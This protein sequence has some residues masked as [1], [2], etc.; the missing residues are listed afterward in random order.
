MGVSSRSLVRRLRSWSVG[1]PVARGTTIHTCVSSSEN[2]FILAFVRMGGESRPW[3]VAWKPGNSKMK[4][5]AI[6]EPRAREF[7]DEMLE[8]LAEDLAFHLGH[9]Y[10][11][12]VEEPAKRAE[13]DSDD[14]PQIWVP[15]SSHI[16]ML[17]FLS[18]S[19]SRRKGD[20]ELDV[21]LRMLGRT[22]LHLFLETRRPGQQLVIDASAALRSAYDFPCEDVR[23]AH[24]GLLIAWLEN[25]G[26]RDNGIS[27]ALE[28]EQLSVSTALDPSLE[29]EEL[30]DLV[31]AFNKSRRDRG[32]GDRTIEK[33]VETI[34]SAELRRRLD[35]VER[36]IVVLKDDERGPNEGLQELAHST[37]QQLFDG[38]LSREAKALDEDREPFALSPETDWDARSASERYYRNEAS[39]DR[40]RNALIH[41]DRELE[42]EA[43]NEGSAFRGTISNVRDEGR[44]KATAPIWTLTDPVPGVL[45]LRQGDKICVVG[46]PLRTGSIRSIT[47]GPDGSLSM[48][49]EITGRKTAQGDK[50]WPHRMAG[51]D[52]SW[53][54]LSVTVISDSFASM[55]EKKA[56]LAGNREPAPADFLFNRLA[57][58]PRVDGDDES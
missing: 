11:D 25:R 20:Q 48:E 23:Q 4:F 40:E 22:A 13:F 39:R 55:T 32:R 46:S 54:G 38:Y 49:I 26:D 37:A 43:I 52:Q 31:E 7:V 3:G 51:A 17:H 33:K 36:A 16:D 14:L 21:N 18:Y 57:Q 6:G 58:R 8:D 47:N 15:N 5:R 24:L 28:A 29:R 50:N 56:Q 10:Y 45:S 1:G 27:A 44:G 34:L 19:Y 41:Y 30:E 35:L 53:L 2:R 9:P 42:A 12:D